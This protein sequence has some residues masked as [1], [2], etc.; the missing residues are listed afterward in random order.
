MNKQFSRLPGRLILAANILLATA[1]CATQQPDLHRLY[2]GGT[3]AEGQPPVVIIPGTLGVRLAYRE[4]GYEIWPGRVRKFI[5]QDY[6]E[7]M[8]P[9]DSAT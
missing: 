5:L 9:I 8:Q 4:T 7:L 1:S 6:D 2:S 3:V